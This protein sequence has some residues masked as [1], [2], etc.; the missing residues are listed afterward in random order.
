MQQS[1]VYRKIDYGLIVS[2]I[3]LAV[4]GLI[5]IYGATYNEGLGYFRMQAIW[6][7]FGLVLMAFFATYAYNQLKHYLIIIYSANLIFLIAVLLFGSTSQGAQRWLQVG[8]FRLQPSEFSK[9][10]MIL[11]LASFLSE[12]KGV[13]KAD[14]VL[15][16]F[17][18]ALPPIF[19]IFQQPDL[20]TSL[21]LIFITI[22]MLLVAGLKFKHFLVIC[23]VGLVLVFI[24]FQFHI[25][26]PYQVNRLM[27]FVD[28]DVDAQGSGYNLMQSKIAV[29]SGG[30]F[31]KGLLSGSQTNL[32]FIPEAHTDFIFAV[33]GEKLGFLG[34]V[35]LIALYFVLLSRGMRTSLMAD[36]F[37][38]SLVAMA[39]V[40]MWLF[41]VT[42]NMGMTIGIMPITGI[43]LPF[44]SY[45][46]SALI[47]N[48]SSGGILLSIYARAIK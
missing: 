29:G 39:I 28:P 31:G 17:A 41:Q 26:K 27:V 47:T 25:L 48:L 23:L 19:L 43:P 15:K 33:L 8:F 18:L 21:V 14:D 40:F 20:G 24:V 16:V 6:F 10:A 13:L 1:K 36:N 12:R 37:F 22:S 30:L 7:T 9:L 42:V 3:S 34:A 46:G 2:V 38:G 11:V 4:Y 35:F 5:L 32:R 45:G 44:M